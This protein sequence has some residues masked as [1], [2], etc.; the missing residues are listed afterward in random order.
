MLR[1]RLTVQHDQPSR[2]LRDDSDVEFSK[3]EGDNVHDFFFQQR[4]LPLNLRKLS[5]L[6]L[7]RLVRDVDV[8]CLQQ[9]I[10]QIAFCSLRE[11]ELKYVTDQQVL[12][13]FRVA[14]LIIEYLLYSQDRLVSNLNK[15]ALKYTAKKR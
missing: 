11:E 12:K 13:L 1:S 5:Q 10:E 14:Q 15:V 4:T 3:R 6:D 8:D 9:Y 7:D 2:S